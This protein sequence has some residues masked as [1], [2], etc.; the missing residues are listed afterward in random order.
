M[1]MADAFLS[2][3]KPGWALLI[4]VDCVLASFEPH[5]GKGTGRQAVRYKANPVGA[6]GTSRAHQP[7]PINATTTVATHPPV[8]IRHI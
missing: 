6:A 8:S 1:V 7:A 2:V 5:L 4:R 3:V